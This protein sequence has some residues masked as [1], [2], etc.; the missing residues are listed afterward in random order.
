M[1]SWSGDIQ[2]AQGLSD[3]AMR[4]NGTASSQSATYDFGDAAK[5]RER[6]RIY[7]SPKREIFSDDDYSSSVETKP[8]AASRVSRSANSV[9]MQVP[10]VCYDALPI[11]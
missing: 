8:L 2:T 9:T 3:E 5:R 7:S 1:T 11:P 6:E 4:G 10:L